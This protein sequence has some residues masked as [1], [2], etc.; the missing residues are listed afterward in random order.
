M[1]HV[2]DNPS[3]RPEDFRSYLLLLARLWLPH[4]LRRTMDASDLVQVTHTKAFEKARQF[5][6]E[7]P[8]Q[9]KAWL[10]RILKNTVL[11]ALKKHGNCPERAFV[12]FDESSSRL[13]NKLAGSGLTPSTLVALQE[14]LDCM[15]E[16]LA[17]LPDDQQQALVLK[18][19]LGWKVAEIAKEWDRSTAAVAGLL[20]RGL[21]QLRGKLAER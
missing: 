10:R 11:D 5:Q 14:E 4:Q 6:G 17:E 19:C 9:Y 16:L 7:Q 20:R 13:E 2:D 8:A 1:H 15:A 18:Y 3:F 21:K 12:Q